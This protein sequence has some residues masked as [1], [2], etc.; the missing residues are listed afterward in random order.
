[1][2]VVIHN[3]FSNSLPPKL[4]KKSP[5]PLPANFKEQILNLFDGFHFPKEFFIYIILS[6]FTLILGVTIGVFSIGVV[7]K[8]NIHKNITMY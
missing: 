2:H 7:W 3:F 1:M 4:C 8:E 5:K 6:I